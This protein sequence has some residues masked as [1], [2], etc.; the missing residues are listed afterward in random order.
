M[1]A[2]IWTDLASATRTSF[3]VAPTWPELALEL[4]RW[5]EDDL[6][7]LDRIA[8]AE[9][10][11]GPFPAVERARTY[12]GRIRR[13]LDEGDVMGAVAQLVEY[14]SGELSVNYGPAIRCGRQSLQ[15]AL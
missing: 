10:P 11:A 5:V 8:G 3:L 1:W 12:G 7:A 15:P 13:R 4:R 14:R 2:A 6:T 9:R